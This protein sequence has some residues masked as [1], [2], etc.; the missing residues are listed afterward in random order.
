[1]QPEFI[2]QYYHMIDLLIH[3]FQFYAMLGQQSII[4]IET[5]GAAKSKH[6]SIG[7]VI[8]QAHNGDYYFQSYGQ[9]TGL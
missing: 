4:P 5:N 8:A 7:F 6:G 2:S 9:P 3:D 1:M